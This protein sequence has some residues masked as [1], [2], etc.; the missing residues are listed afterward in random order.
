MSVLD[1]AVKQRQVVAQEY[2]NVKEQI[3][4]KRQQNM[5]KANL[6]QEAM[7]QKLKKNETDSWK[8]T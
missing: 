1:L 5:V 6:R 8:T 2:K 3:C 7:K 4:K